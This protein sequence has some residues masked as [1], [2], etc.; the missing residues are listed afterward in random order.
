MAKV[1]VYVP[2]DLWQ[3]AQAQS[4]PVNLSQIFQQALRAELR[5]AGRY[6]VQA[7]L[8]AQLDLN[9]LR[10]RF[11][12]QR[13]DLYRRGYAIGIDSVQRYLGYA[14]L[15]FCEDTGW[16]VDEIMQHLGKDDVTFDKL[17]DVVLEVVGN[18]GSIFQTATAQGVQIEVAEGFV[19]ALRRVWEL[20]VTEL[21]DEE[22][23][24]RR[25]FWE[26]WKDKQ[27]SVQSAKKSEPSVATIN[28]DGD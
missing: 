5:R 25:E 15:R 14:D 10:E 18:D 7:D 22:R 12:H 20:V 1:T 17:M 8:D 3:R 26:E 21:V 9:A 4:E 2:D 27:R 19:A 24:D 11:C 6:Q 13:I 16:D 23:P 28:E